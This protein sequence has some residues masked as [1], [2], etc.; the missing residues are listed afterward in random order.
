MAFSGYL[1]AVDLAADARRL[2]E[3]A[4]VHD[5]RVRAL[6]SG[7][8]GA[9]AL[10]GLLVIRASAPALWQG[11]TS[12]L[13]LAL[14]IVSVVAG[15]VTAI[16]LWRGG[17]GLAWASAA[18]AV[19]GSSRAGPKAQ[20]PYALPGLTV[21]AAAAGWSTLI[22]TIVGV[23]VGAVVLV[24][25]LAALYS[26]V[27]RGRLDMAE[28]RMRGRQRTPWEA[29]RRWEAGRQRTAQR[30][31][32]AGPATGPGGG[33]AGPAGRGVRRRGLGGGN[34]AAGL[35][36]PGLGARPRRRGPDRL[37]GDGLRAGGAAGQRATWAA[38]AGAV[39][40]DGTRGLTRA[41]AALSWY[42]H[43]L[44]RYVLSCQW[45]RIAEEEAFGGR[46]AEAGDELGSA[47][48]MA[49]LARDLMRL[50][51]AH[52]LPL[53]AVQQVAGQRPRPGPPAAPGSAPR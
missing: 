17:F 30:R 52:A 1:A 10:A 4:L 38:P 49:R 3:P 19:A 43:D 46:R 29:V 26:L 11:S 16:L 47:I 13:G 12:G 8:G 42:P 40:H 9:L 24:P 37:R 28:T 39:F 33:A 27:L 6:V 35:R 21:A 41:R 34:R 31:C 20:A 14:V 53:P 23:A 7:G 50:S 15:V 22:A 48:V 45:S 2:A 18:L 51:A 32:Q 44:W 36:R 5:F 25:L